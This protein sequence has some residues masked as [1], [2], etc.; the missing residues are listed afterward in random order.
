MTGPKQPPFIFDKEK[1][2]GITSKMLEAVL[3][4]KRREIVKEW[5]EVG[6]I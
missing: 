4:E 3:E 6:K 1:A 5:I 2:K